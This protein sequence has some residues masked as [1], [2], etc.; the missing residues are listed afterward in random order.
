MA[1]ES[2]NIN[3]NRF[4]SQK[5][6]ADILSHVRYLFF[7]VKTKDHFLRSI[8]TIMNQIWETGTISYSEVRMTSGQNS[9]APKFEGRGSERIK[10][11]K[12]F[13]FKPIDRQF[14]VV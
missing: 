8:S 12:L 13:L 11:Q 4:A 14:K 6:V 7:P 9:V 3:K 1:D 5:I 2:R 10:S